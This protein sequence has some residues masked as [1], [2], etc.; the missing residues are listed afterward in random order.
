MTTVAMIGLGRMGGP[1]A[2]HVIAAG[3]DVRVVDLSP[4]AVAPRVEAGATAAATPADAARGAS[5]VGVVVLDDAQATEVIAGS[6]GVL[7]ALEPGA[8]VA[9]HTTVSLTT[10][11]A[12]AELG[13]RYDI[14][15]LDAG[16][17]GGEAG[18]QQGTLLTMVGGE[19]AAVERAR[20]VMECYS[21]E[22]L[23]AGPAGAGM[24]L[25]LAR[26]AVG[27]AMMATVHDAL[28]LTHRSGID[29][30]MLRHVIAETG[31]FDQ[32]LAPLSFGGP[33]PLPDDAPPQFRTILEHTGL[34]AAKDLEQALDL[35]HELGASVPVI[36]TTRAGF[37]RVVRL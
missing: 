18:A 37:S 12:L 24:A 22:V 4:S 15:V 6:S 31:V 10:F 25:K 30:A 7:H 1:M 34:L 23:H 33:G 29:V 9:V 13:R 16:I 35:A 36:E 19:A 8:V 27:Y 28:E 17:S 2:D 3:H 21:K 20:A 26:N 5:F 14:D 32:S 11:R